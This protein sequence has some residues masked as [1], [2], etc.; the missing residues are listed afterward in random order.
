MFEGEKA[1]D[2][3]GEEGSSE[4]EEDSLGFFRP[5]DTPDCSSG[6]EDPV[7]LPS[8][9]S[10]EW[11]DENSRWRFKPSPLSTY[12]WLVSIVLRVQ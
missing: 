3:G 6:E 9:G 12:T 1:S 8:Q 10:P 11:D 4:L 2:D 7:S 5:V